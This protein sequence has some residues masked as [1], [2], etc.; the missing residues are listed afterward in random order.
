[1]YGDCI[2]DAYTSVTRSKRSP[3]GQGSVYAVGGTIYRPGGAAA[4]ATLARG[5]G[6]DV[7]LWGPVGVD[8]SSDIL[9]SL[10][11]KAGV[12][13]R[14]D[15]LKSRLT[16]LKTRHVCEG[17]LLPD[18]FDCER[19]QSYS[20]Q[21]FDYGRMLI[22][23]DYDKGACIGVRRMIQEATLHGGTVI[24]DPAKFA[25]WSRYKGCTIIKPNFAEGCIAAKSLGY[26][27]IK[28]DKQSIATFLSL[29]MDCIV[30]L[31]CSDKGLYVAQEGNFVQH[32]PAIPVVVK[33]VTGAGDTCAAALACELFDKTLSNKDY[34]N[35]ISACEVAV[36]KAALQVSLIG[37][38]NV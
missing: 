38:C 25:N 27:C 8:P 18:R 30:V 2:L 13:T 10:L 31:S 16:P 22:I 36:E 32:I 21:P 5:L 37:V 17:S 11:S 20:A 29:K 19:I 28:Q 34:D 26:D 7:R 33:D 35:L 12:I 1:V 23:S 3:E 14:L 9:A 15:P 6:C 4:V 24:V